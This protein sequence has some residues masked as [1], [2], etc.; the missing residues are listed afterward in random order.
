MLQTKKRLPDFIN[1]SSFWEQFELKVARKDTIRGP[2]ATYTF[3]GLLEGLAGLRGYHLL[4]RKTYNRIIKG[5]RHIT[6]SLEESTHRPPTCCA[7]SLPRE[8]CWRLGVQGFY[9]GLV[10]GTKTIIITIKIPDTQ[11]ESRHSVPQAGKSVI[12]EARNSSK[13]KFSGSSQ[14]PTLQSRPF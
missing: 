9:W 3:G 2:T 11:K 4:Q 1:R 5:K 8:A 7:M 14:K 6:W 10:T 13:A 12:W